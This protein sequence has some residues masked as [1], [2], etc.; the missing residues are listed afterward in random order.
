MTVGSG[1]FPVLCTAG[2]RYYAE[3]SVFR[4]SIE[5]E[6]SKFFAG[7]WLARAKDGSIHRS[8]R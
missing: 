8:H 4:V 1:M 2:D 3:V 5:H 7:T 6:K